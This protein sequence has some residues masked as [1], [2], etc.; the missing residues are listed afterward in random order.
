[1]RDDIKFILGTYCPKKLGIPGF[2]NDSTNYPLYDIPI[3]LDYLS[4][5]IYDHVI[6]REID[7]YPFRQF[8]DNLLST[9]SRLLNNLSSFRFRISFDYT[10]YMMKIYNLC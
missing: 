9:V 7:E 6:S 2:E 1:M 3:A 5:F 8:I 10:L 4:Q